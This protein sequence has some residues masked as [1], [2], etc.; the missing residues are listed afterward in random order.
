MWQASVVDKGCLRGTGKK[1]NNK[2]GT[3]C[4]QVGPYMLTIRPKKKQILSFK[5]FVSR[6]LVIF[7]E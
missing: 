3:G 4:M 1:V 6:L 7:K 5:D 2:K